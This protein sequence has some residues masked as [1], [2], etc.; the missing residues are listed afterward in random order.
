MRIAALAVVLAAVPA[1]AATPPRAENLARKAK[2]SATTEYSG[3]YLAKFATDGVV[4]EPLSHE[5]VGR[6][7]AV[8]GDKERNGSTFTLEW[9]EAVKVA[10]IVYYARTAWFLEE[11]WK[12]Y[13]VLLD[14]NAAPVA[15]GTLA[16]D[17]RPQRIKV[18]PASAKRIT[19]KFLSSYGGLNPGASEIEVYSESPP[20]EALTRVGGPAAVPV[21]EESPELA[22]AVAEGKLGFA[23]LAVVQRQEL[24]PSHV[25]TACA[26]GFSPGGGLYLLSPAAP[27]G[28]LQE[29]VASPKGQIQ[30][31]DV[32]YD[33]KE[34]LFSWRKEGNLGY[35]IYRVNADGTGLTQL[36]DGECHDYNV[37]CLPDGGIAFVSTRAAIV[38]LCWTTPAGALYR[39]DRDGQN[40]RRLSANY[41]NDFTPSVLPDGRI[42]YS[43][44]EY[45]DKPAIP[46]QSVWTI[47][48]DG[49]NLSVFY[50]NGVLSP[51]SM[52]EA[53]GIPGTTDVLCTLTSHNGPIRGGVGLISRNYGLDAQAAMFSLTPEVNIGQAYRGSGNSVRGP[54]ENPYPVDTE[55]FLV[56][57]K[58]SICVGSRSGKWAVVK[59]REGRLGLYNPVP[60]R[61]RP[62][63]PVLASNTKAEGDLQSSPASIP[64]EATV[65][66]LDI[67]EGLEPVVP[68]GT[69]RQVAVVQ[70]L[71]KSI[72]THVLGFGFQRPVISC[73]ATYAPKKVWG[74]AK[75]EADGS[76][77]F[78]V[79]TDVP[80]YF[81]ALDAS[82]QA[83]QR[84]RSFTH[85][86]PGERRGCI[87][88]H[89]P[90]NATPRTQQP[91]AAGRP[92]EALTAPEWG[93]EHF[94]YSRI[95][96]PVLDKHCVKCH[97]GADPPQRV[98]LTGGKTEWFNVSYDTL[99][100]GYVSW[101]NTCNGNEANILQIAPKAWGSP[102]SKLTP[103]LMGGH[104]DKEGKPRFTLSDAERR[105][106]FTWVDLNIPYYSTYD[107]AY[108]DIEGG[109]RLVPKDLKAKLAEVAQRRCTECHQ[110]AVPSRGYIRITE[111][112]LNDFLVAPLAKAAG[113]R[114]AC[115]KPVFATKDDPDYQ[116]LLKCFDPV[117]A[118]L[119]QKPR[120]DMPGAVAAKVNDSCQ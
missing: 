104:V 52:L 111:P 68:R 114:E 91:L 9:P 66:I 3:Q 99:T 28:K 48:P 32:S 86:V 78:K 108:P 49:T 2:A 116:L 80:I 119:A 101:I 31:L 109:R 67:Y 70:E 21:A 15:K 1:L 60:L 19:I 23:T 65:Y 34:I 93:T 45:V 110:K 14:G 71:A 17:P 38:P 8:K 85:F 56:S 57:K 89:E 113:G 41:V 4:P 73:G 95:V 79:P 76:A 69:V 39:M 105:R 37:A 112:E 83:V 16:M 97:G 96:Q 106:L 7:W 46:I 54:Y 18:Q 87:G 92:P 24:N 88:C 94:D 53:R 107:M 50:G 20:K 90:R 25:Y 36:T 82:G 103:I 74:F 62:V 100:H 51:A 6:A 22:K 30:D 27:D 81:L 55:H 64:A 84:M 44:W 98:D 13:E 29:L 26:E 58:G 35:H 43:R 117:R 63:P 5:D 10:E 72:R 102:A 59:P 75:V 42:I 118:L 115:K 61:P 120:M 33:G 12:D 77:H 11:G 47:H 40:M